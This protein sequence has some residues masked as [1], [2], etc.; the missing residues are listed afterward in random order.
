MIAMMDLIGDRYLMSII[1]FGANQINKVYNA[2]FRM[3]TPPCP[4]TVYY[5][6]W[7]S[8]MFEEFPSGEAIRHLAKDLDGRKQMMKDP[9]FRESFKKEFKNKYAPKVWHKDLSIATIIDCPDKNLIGKNFI[10]IAE[11][12]KKHPVE[13]FLDLLVKYDRDIR[14]KTTIANDR[15]EKYEYLYN[16]PYTL[17]SFSDA[18][19]HLTNMA[20]YNFP[21]KMIK[22][23]QDSID[24]KKP[25]MS[26]EKC[27]W[28]LSGEQGDWFNLNKGYVKEGADADINI[29]D[30]AYLKNVHEQDI[31]NAPIEEFGGFNRLVNRNKNVMSH[32]L[33]NGQVIWENQAFVEDYGKTKKYGK[34]LRAKNNSN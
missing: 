18:G 28:R 25:I 14:W 19:A 6:G 13:S 27:I 33:V 32:V 15:V 7:D 11:E 26:M 16:Y 8:I 21:L 10:Q 17:M 29:I 3:Q 22:Y 4:F 24:A 12:Q 20:F 34:F 1:S 5:D 2:D 23:V 31:E 9:K 30:P